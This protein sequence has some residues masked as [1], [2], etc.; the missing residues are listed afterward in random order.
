[1]N[2][3]L[4][5]T[6]KPDERTVDLMAIYVDKEITFLSFCFL[7]FFLREGGGI[8]HEHIFKQKQILPTIS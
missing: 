8:V 1:M 2:M 5:F 6:Q 4:F 3:Q 7:V